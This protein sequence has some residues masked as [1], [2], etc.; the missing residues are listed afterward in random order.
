MET[1]FEPTC[2]RQK[3]NWSKAG[4]DF[5]F[6]SASFNPDKLLAEIETRSPKL[7][8]LLAKI[9]ALDKSDMA[10]DGQVYKHFI[11]SDL[12]SNSYGV[13]LLAS[14]FIAKGLNIGYLAPKRGEL[15][16]VVSI[17]DKSVT[18][19]RK[20][21]VRIKSPIIQDFSPSLEPPSNMSNLSEPPSLRSNISDITMSE[22][23]NSNIA[24]TPS[25]ES[26]SEESLSEA[27]LPEESLPDESLSEES[28]SEASLSEASLPEES[29]SEASLPS[30][31]SLPEESSESKSE[32]GIGSSISNIATSISNGFSSI[33]SPVASPVPSPSDSLSALFRKIGI[34]TPPSDSPV[35]DLEE[36]RRELIANKLKIMA[37][38]GTDAAELEAYLNTLKASID[39]RSPSPE[40]SA[41]VGGAPTKNKHSKTAK[42]Q[43]VWGKP[44]LKT[45]KELLRT[46]GQNFYLLS[47][48]GMYDMPITVATKKSI[49]KKFNQRPENIH[50]E[51]V[52]FIIMDSGF[53]EGIDL[54]DIKYIHIFEP[55]IVPADQTQTI[56][57]GTR[58]CG[59]KGLDFHPTRGW[60]LHVFI[61]DLEIPE[62]FRDGFNGAN[63][64]MDLYLKSLNI[65]L[66]IMNFASALEEVAIMGSVDYELNKKIHS[67]AIAKDSPIRSQ[68]S[69]I[70]S[71]G[72]P[73]RSQGSPIRSQGSPIRSPPKLSE[74]LYSMPL[75][76]SLYSI[77]L[78]QR[79]TIPMNNSMPLSQADTVVTGGESTGG[80]STG[81][82]A[83]SVR[84]LLAQIETRNLPKKMGF[85]EMRRYIDKNYK[86]FEWEDVKMENLCVD[87]K[88]GG[89]LANSNITNEI[90]GGAGPQLIK[91]SPTQDFVKHYF[92]PQNPYKGML[93]WHSV[94]TGKTCSAIAAASYSFEQ[95]GY[96]ILWVTR[97]TLKNDIWKNMFEQVCSDRI[98]TIVEHSN[99]SN[100]NSGKN[101]FPEEQNKRMRLLSQSWKIRPMS[102]KQFSNLVSKQNENYR[103]LVGIN[104]AIDPLRKT[105]IIIDEAHKLYGASDLSALERPDMAALHQ[106][107]MN[108]YQI[109][110]ADSVKM[111]LMTATPITK[112]PLE[113]VKLLNLCRPIAEQMPTEFDHF[114]N[115]YLDEEGRFSA[116]GRARFLDDIAGQISYLN[117]E[118]DARQF[119]QPVIKYIRPSIIANAGDIEMMD[120]RYVREYTARGIGE[121][122]NRVLEQNAK[123]EGDLGE[124]NAGKFAFLKRKCDME[125]D[126]PKLR[127]KCV[128][129]VNR[130]IKALVAEA[131]LE[132]QV[133]KDL[134]KEIKSDI[135]G[136]TD[137]RKDKSAAIAA[138]IRDNPDKL[139]D[140]QNTNY[141][142][143]KYKCG[144]R[145]DPNKK[146]AEV[147]SAAMGDP[148]IWELEGQIQAIDQTIAG[149]QEQLK[150]EIEQYKN[151]IRQLQ[152]LLKTN[153]TSLEKSAVR[154]EIQ[155]QRK[156]LRNIS[157][158]VKKDMSK[159]M[160]AINKTRKEIE[161]SIATGKKEHR[162]AIIKE[163]KETR[164]REL[165][166]ANFANKEERKTRKMLQKQGEY[167]EIKNAAINE[168]VNKYSAEI[169]HEYGEL[170]A[171]DQLDEANK[172]R[173]KVAKDEN[174]TKKAQEKAQKAQEKAHAKVQVAAQNQANKTQ[175][176]QEKAHAKEEVAA[177]KAHTK[178]QV[179]AQKAQ[180]KAYIAAQKAHAKDQVA[181]QKAQEK[182]YIAAQKAQVAALKEEQKMIRPNKTRRLPIPPQEPKPLLL[183][184]QLQQ[185]QQSQFP[186][187]Q[188]TML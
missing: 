122:Q 108:S 157:T 94:G 91:F 110:G 85:A 84:E 115:Q 30:D 34:N 179:A 13:K 132:S 81:G 168:L 176:A 173:T 125:V 45:D 18:P 35:S 80:E 21:V 135:K 19:K 24:L 149:K 47:S 76:E 36:Y 17:S 134:I 40:S 90:S 46:T 16:P 44:Y 148:R 187:I 66:R 3:S 127:K 73:I 2:I 174:K 88:T 142:N 186:V 52:R 153:I 74:S 83:K 162:K 53:K 139:A 165:K 167:L 42:N 96:T 117:R 133:I 145:V 59:Q 72:S 12:K 177:Q 14:A 57:R 56:G 126:D 102:Y 25:R 112:D 10:R 62:Q 105:L 71:Q 55:S 27:S 130:H 43:K 11:F 146:S 128:S 182:A 37:Q 137:I 111:L 184:P 70:R 140:F 104:G 158:L 188:E 113:L 38:P 166:E 123:L 15:R 54:F 164:K 161:K 65:D 33:I 170:L 121:L 144:K 58:T 155:N 61:Y 51:L 78:S 181:A 28:L 26:L 185:Q 159:E 20:S 6:E 50:G 131:K 101:E 136:K 180:E 32:S 60:P 163:G 89:Q 64:A 150:L 63:G 49:L 119:A 171:Q 160:G 120:N 129:M 9:E 175:K 106:S 99:N 138:Y 92:T 22:P 75:S 107:L 69:P 172:L 4:D 152:D 95:Q 116:P 156:T 118:K 41:T 1:Q 77:P 31:E 86:Q 82:G 98:R 7:D 143:I 23:P 147:N 5:K 141:Y 124:I 29:L 169:E 178:D 154:V 48:T 183:R 8:A 93:L 100:S 114:A 67:F 39:S 97:T 79:T 109:S 151:Q 103:T 87:K 68:G